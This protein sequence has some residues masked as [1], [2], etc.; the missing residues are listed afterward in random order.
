MAPDTGE[1]ANPLPVVDRQSRPGEV[2]RLL[3]LGIV[4]MAVV[5]L[6]FL[7]GDR[8]GEPFRLGLLGIFAMVGVFYLFA[9]VIGII[10]IAPRSTGN[11]MSRALLDGASDGT[12]VSDDRGRIIYANKAYSTICGM[13]APENIILIF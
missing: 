7:F 4:L 11:E 8:L 6:F 9:S 12:I 3:V 2:L 10:R 13:S 1:P 5:A